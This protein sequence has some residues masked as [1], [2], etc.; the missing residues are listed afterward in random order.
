M[1]SLQ[2]VKWSS[3]LSLITAFVAAVFLLVLLG[4]GVAGVSASPTSPTD[5]YVDAAIGSDDSDCSDP[6]DPCATIGYGV[7]QANDGD[8]VLISADTYTENIEYDSK[9]LTL[10]GGYAIS[11][12]TWLSGS[13]ETVVDGDNADR[14]FFVHSNDSIF[15]DLTIFNG[16][17]PDMEPWGGGIWVTNGYFMMRRVTVYSNTNG[18]I[19]VNSD[20][21]PTH[22]VLEDSISM[23]NRGNGGLNVSETDASAEVVNALI[24]DNDGG[25]AVRLESGNQDA[26]WLTIMNSTIANTLNGPGID[27]GE[28]GFFTL[29][30]SIVWGDDFGSLGCIGTCIVTYSDLEDMVYTGTGNISD[31]PLF[32]D[33]GN[34]NY[35]L[36]PGS[37]AINGGTAIGAPPYDLDGNMRD[38][39][40][41]MGCYE[42][43]PPTSVTSSS[44]ERQT[45]PPI[46]GWM[47]L[48]ILVVGLGFLYRRRRIRT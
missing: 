23:G 17:A 32:L 4:I 6:T 45:G 7:D 40:P 2:G 28:G 24:V 5:R 16:H 3:G 41:D 30:N 43:Q 29:T 35:H 44:F 27:I 46:A 10:R 22:L 1:K 13:G 9:S 48:L 20:F 34:G 12:S 36:G 33:P 15:E 18:G 42:Y 21:G 47:A 19:E 37:P 26:G 39:N 14:V 31:D 8:Y 38:A 11:G 25:P